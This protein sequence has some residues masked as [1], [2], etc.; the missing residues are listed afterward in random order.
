MRSS[1]SIIGAYGYDRDIWLRA[2][3][4]FSSG[5]VRV[6]PMITHRLPLS[7]AEQGFEMA[8]RKEAAKVIFLP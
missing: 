6:E 8:V 2:L 3:H 5:K 7:E 4:L 1:K